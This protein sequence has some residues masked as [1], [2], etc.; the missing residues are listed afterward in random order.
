MIGRRNCRPNAPDGSEIH[1]PPPSR[2]PPPR[3]FP[4]SSTGSF[5]EV[6]TG[7]TAT[8]ARRRGAFLM[9]VPTASDWLWPR[10]V[11][12]SPSRATETQPTI[13][14]WHNAVPDFAETD[15]SHFGRETSRQMHGA[16]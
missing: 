9:I 1:P 5:L 6:R 8:T 15:V 3:G 4:A 16:D 10:N 11:A 13:A 2:G 7:I 12:V 14:R